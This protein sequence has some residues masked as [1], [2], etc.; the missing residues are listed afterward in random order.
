MFKDV[1]PMNV[2]TLLLA[3][4]IG[5]SPVISSWGSR[6]TLQ[7]ELAKKMDA[8]FSEM[9]S[10]FTAQIAELKAQT[11]G[12]PDQ[13]AAIDTLRGAISDLRQTNSEMNGRL[14][15]LEM[16]LPD[17]QARVDGIARASGQAPVRR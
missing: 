13:R 10:S 5:V 11:A 17:L 3:L 15:A 9:K 7:D 6:G 4:I 12:I 16:A 8:G 2:L 14:R 1:T